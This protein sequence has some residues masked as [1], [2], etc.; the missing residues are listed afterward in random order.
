MQQLRQACNRAGAL[1]IL[2][3]AQAGLGRTGKLWAFEQFDIMPDILLLAKAVGGGMPL[4]AFI[5]SRNIMQSLADN[6]ALG[7]IT[8]FGGH[9]VCCAAGM[10]AFKTMLQEGWIDQVESKGAMFER[11][12]NHPRIRAIRR[13]GL[14]MALEFE[15]FKENKKI[16]DRCLEYG[17][18]TDWFLFAPQ[19]MRIAPPLI[20]T[21]PEIKEACGIM[22]ECLDNA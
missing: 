9:P 21:E 12:L 8:T 5:S 4:G 13:I 11:M 19:S 14:L 7:H 3:E 17:V 6:P 22:L 10:A 15:N 18:L 16:I 20:I 2:D 1:L